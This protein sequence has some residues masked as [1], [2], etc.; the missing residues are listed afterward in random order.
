MFWVCSV[1]GQRSCGGF[2]GVSLSR[3]VTGLRLASFVQVSFV[4]PV[5]VGAR[6][7]TG[8]ETG[9][10]QNLWGSLN[11]HTALPT[12]GPPSQVPGCSV[13]VVM[14]LVANL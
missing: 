8:S 1:V 9:A 4:C 2:Q 6:L 11:E 3:G 14:Y 5:S 12:P 13:G 10:A 7:T